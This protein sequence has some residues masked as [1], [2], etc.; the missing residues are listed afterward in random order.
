MIIVTGGSGFIGSALVWGLNERGHED[1]LVVDQ[2]ETGQKWKNLRSLEYLDYMN[3]IQ[4]LEHVENDT[5]PYD[6]DAVLHLGACSATTEEDLEF[7][8]ENNY[9]YTKELARWSLEHGARFLY[10][11]SAAVYG[12]GEKGYS[13]DHD[14]IPDL[15]PLNKYA[16]SKQRFDEFALRQGWLNEIVGLRYFNV[17]G[18]NEYHKGE[19]RSVVNKSLPQARDEG[20]IR[21]FQSHRDDIED[22][23]QKRDF[24]YVKDAVN[25]TLHLL[26]NED[27]SGIY[28][29]GTG[30]ARPFDDL[31]E[32]IFDA[33]DEPSR[34]EYFEMPE[35]LRE[36]YQYFTEADLTKL[37]D[38]GYDQPITSLEEA[39]RD[40]VTNYLLRDDPYL[41]S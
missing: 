9:R 18:P 8:M 12:D 36:N 41:T 39:V 17:Y 19:M 23:Q 4:F 27:T 11:S 15:E 37:R 14:R 2:F 21:L 35:H 26:E 34:I 6:P 22:G 31:A 32:A 25:M 40:Y 29:I 30:Q 33:L 5:L 20:V 38:S 1:I 10:A 16:F 13:D 28:N 24:L 7:L 3:K